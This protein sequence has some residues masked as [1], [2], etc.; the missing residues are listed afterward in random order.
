[1]S[2]SNKLADWLSGVEKKF[3][4]IVT[5]SAVFSAIVAFGRFDKSTFCDKIWNQ[6][7]LPSL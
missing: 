6:K 2:D 4:I 7:N 3:Y 5:G 1:M